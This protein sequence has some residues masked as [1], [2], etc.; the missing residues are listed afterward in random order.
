MHVDPFGVIA[1]LAALEKE[2]RVLWARVVRKRYS[3]GIR[4]ICPGTQ[5]K[6][7]LARFS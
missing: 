1:E 5:A 2:T 6:C 3:T 7:I 4:L